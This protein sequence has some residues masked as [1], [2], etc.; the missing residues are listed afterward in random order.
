ML[1]VRSAVL[2]ASFLFLVQEPAPDLRARLEAI[3]RATVDDALLPGLSVEV[4][5]GDEVLASRG[6]GYSHAGQARREGP[7]LVRAC[8]PALEPMIAV[9]ALRLARE[10]RLELAAP[11]AE[12]LP[13]LREHAAGVRVEQL[14]TH[15]SGLPCFGDLARARGRALDGAEVLAWAAERPLDAEPGT[16]FAPSDTDTVLAGLIVAQV[17]GTDLASALRSLVIEPAGL[18]R[19]AFAASAAELEAGEREEHDELGRDLARSSLGLPPLVST[20][21][22]MTRFVRELQGGELLGADGLATL[23]APVT[24]DRGEAPFARGFARAR[25]EGHDAL[26][27]GSAEG[28]SVFVS[29][30]PELDLTVAL[31]TTTETTLLSAI[32]RRLVRAL[33]DAPEPGL[34]DEPIPAAELAACAGSYYLGCTRVDIEAR[35]TALHFASPYGE[36][37]RLMRQA[38]HRFVADVDPDVALEFHV[39]GGLA[40]EFVLTRRGTQ[41]VARRLD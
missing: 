15:T 28:T 16:C 27:F 40:S 4:T 11:I 22:D 29:W 20:L 19:T 25:L 38:R 2:A 12:F 1:P 3:A 39:A 24:V 37:F 13:E 17:A 33:L 7:D 35:G 21:G 10:R 30:Y 14:L 41:S 5:W 31:A 26:V 34:L 9:A 8:D 32:E 36:T 23:T 18:E 6:F